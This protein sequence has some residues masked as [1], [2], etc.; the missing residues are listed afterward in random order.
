MNQLVILIIALPLLFM[1]HD[2]EEMIVRKAWME[3]YAPALYKR[4][5]RMEQ[6]IRRLQGMSSAAFAIAVAEEFIILSLVSVAVLIGN[7]EQW[8]CWSWIALLWAFSFHL[9]VHIA[10][11]VVLRQYTPGVVTSVLCLPYSVYTLYVFTAAGY[12]LFVQF[13]CALMGIVCMVLNLYGMHRAG[14]SV[15]RFLSTRI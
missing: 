2:F 8:L 9:L 12:S 7:L 11:G 10:Q 14:I 15:D 5:P 1:L 13:V 4:F 6:P 3:K